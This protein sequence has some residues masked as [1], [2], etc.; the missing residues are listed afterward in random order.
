MQEVFYRAWLD[1]YPNVEAGIS[2]DDVEDRFK[3]RQSEEKLA[4]R[5]EDI[6]NHD[7]NKKYLVA[8]DGDKVVGLCRA[9]RKEKENHL[10]AIYILPDYQGRGIGT[11][12]WN[13]IKLFFDPKKDTVLGV[14]EY[15]QKA[16]NFYS[17]LGFVDTGRRHKEEWTK[18]KSG[19]MLPEMDMVLV[20]K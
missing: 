16:I 1:T 12:M 2:I 4:K 9:E 5:R 15:N 19:A 7:E 14:A 3:G 8:L 18:M 13:E 11:M 10:N 6:I 17:R 20:A